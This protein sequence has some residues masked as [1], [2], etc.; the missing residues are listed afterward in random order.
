MR[1][2]IDLVRLRL[3]RL[4]HLGHR[5]AHRRIQ[6]AHRLHALHR[7]ERRVA[8]HLIANLG[9]IDVDNIAQRI[10]R[11]VGNS[12]CP[13]AAIDPDPFV[14]LG[15]AII[16]GISHGWILSSAQGETLV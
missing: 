5:A 6:I 12:N 2:G 7:T 10:L 14:F 9:R 11:V 8:L 13:D 1:S 16:R 15:V 3:Q 4:V